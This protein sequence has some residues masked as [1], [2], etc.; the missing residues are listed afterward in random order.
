MKPIL[1]SLCWLSLAMC[2]LG[3]DAER[4]ELLAEQETV[5]E[6][7]GVQYQE[8]RGLTA[9]C[10]DKCG[11]SGNFARFRIIKYLIYKKPG[12]YGDPQ[13]PEFVTQV[14]DNLGKLKLPVDQVKLIRVLQKGDYV[15]LSWRH[16]YVTK[17]GTSQPER[18]MTRVE[19]LS[20]AEAGQLAGDTRL[21]AT[22]AKP[23]VAPTP[24]AF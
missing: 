23:G 13:V 21:E 17:D 11:G 6:F 2:A 15:R 4:R 5:A 19:K 1:F 22:P 18:P 14:D 24:R 8:C 12:E 20:K 3:V 7:L 16:D 9:L 10:P